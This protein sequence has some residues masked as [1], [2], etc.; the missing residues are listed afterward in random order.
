[1]MF[2]ALSFVMRILGRRI[3]ARQD[4]AYELSNGEYRVTVK[5]TGEVYSEAIYNPF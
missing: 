4:K 3:K 5:E 1:M 2:T